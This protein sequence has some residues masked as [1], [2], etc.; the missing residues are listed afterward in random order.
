MGEFI[1]Y[2]FVAG[3]MVNLFTMI[4]DD[5][6]E[7]F[8]EFGIIGFFLQLLLSTVFFPWVVM[9]CVKEIVDYVTSNT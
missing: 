7:G 1:F 4:S 9:A 5:I 6:R 8:F 2:Y 3:L